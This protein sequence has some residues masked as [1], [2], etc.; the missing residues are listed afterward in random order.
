MPRQHTASPRL[1]RFLSNIFANIPQ[2][3]SYIEACGRRDVFAISLQLP[4]DVIQKLLPTRHTTSLLKHTTVL[5]IPKFLLLPQ[6]LSVVTTALCLSQQL[7]ET[8]L[9]QL[10][11]EKILS[12]VL[13]KIL[14]LWTYA[15]TKSGS[16]I[17][18]LC[19]VDSAAIKELL[20]C[21]SITFRIEAVSSLSCV[22]ALECYSQLMQ[23]V[24]PCCRSFL[25]CDLQLISALLA[26]ATSACMPNIG[27]IQS[28][29]TTT[30]QHSN[31]HPRHA[32]FLSIRLTSPL[33]I[34]A[35]TFSCLRASAKFSPSVDVLLHS[36]YS[37]C[38]F[39]VDEDMQN[40]LNR[41]IRTNRDPFHLNSHAVWKSSCSVLAQDFNDV[42][43]SPFKL[44][45]RWLRIIYFSDGR[46]QCCFNLHSSI[47][48]PAQINPDVMEPQVFGALRTDAASV[49]SITF[50]CMEIFSLVSLTAEG[51]DCILLDEAAIKL[52]MDICSR[53]FEHISLRVFV[54][55]TL[56]NFSLQSSKQ[57]LELLLRDFSLEFLKDSLGMRNVEV[58]QP[59][60]Q[61]ISN[62]VQKLGSIGK[63]S[64]SPL[65]I[66]V[67][68]WIFFQKHLCSCIV[69]AALHPVPAVMRSAMYSIL[70]ACSPGNPPKIRRFFA[71]S[72]IFNILAKILTH[73]QQHLRLLALGTVCSV[74]DGDT[75]ESLRWS[76]V[77]STIID[78]V[79]LFQDKGQGAID[80]HIRFMTMACVHNVSIEPLCWENGLDDM[81]VQAFLSS[82]RQIL[83]LE[84]P[85]CVKLT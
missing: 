44:A 10:Q 58:I 35:Q 70:N 75:I 78:A 33:E 69:A 62:I 1:H 79:S 14:E 66:F 20:F 64:L 49:E 59:C 65:P 30:P 18:E 6:A 21:P 63:T 38:R 45:V 24:G 55:T 43:F 56:H 15:S 22:L 4:L 31:F 80:A 81:R 2:Y 76:E 57:S 26:C 40:R 23:R 77:C 54:L 25:S 8:L 82:A 7:T 61:V 85:D 48:A 51:R 67:H 9:K 74:I 41:V 68:F 13:V 83:T 42:M 16:K 34:V 52:A 72:G 39:S 3:R 28:H 71:A 12:L 50:S 29:P 32:A 46:S 5:D 60:L 47:R 73:P 19:S 37:D 84:T 36:P 27:Q 17:E 11:V 53:S